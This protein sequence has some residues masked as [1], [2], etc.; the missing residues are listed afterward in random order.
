MTELQIVINAMALETIRSI[1]YSTSVTKVEDKLRF[2]G[3]ILEAVEDKP[4]AA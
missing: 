2:I 4:V 3:Y 1:M